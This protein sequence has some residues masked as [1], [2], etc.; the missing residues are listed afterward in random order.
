MGHNPKIEGGRS[1]ANKGVLRSSDAR[2]SRWRGKN[3]A[4][5]VCTPHINSSQPLMVCGP[6]L[7]ILNTGAPCC[8]NKIFCKHIARIR[9][10][11]AYVGVQPPATGGQWGAGGSL[12]HS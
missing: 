2:Q 5:S 10:G 1:S 4:D 6:L 7:E 3:L 9:H 11:G 8:S 12:R